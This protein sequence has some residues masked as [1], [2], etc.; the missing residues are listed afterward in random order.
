MKTAYELLLEAPDKQVTRLQ[1]VFKCIAAGEWAD[2]AVF[3]RN[4][5]KEEFGTDWAGEA[6]LLADACE[7]QINP[8]AL[9][10]ASAATTRA[11]DE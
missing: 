11:W 10:S 7:K 9:V 4:G 2:A 3:L 8:Y 6:G 1:L 5:A